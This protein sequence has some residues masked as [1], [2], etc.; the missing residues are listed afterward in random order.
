MTG[1]GSRAPALRA[2]PRPLSRGPVL[3]WGPPFEDDDGRTG[4]FSP[5][6]VMLLSSPGPEFSPLSFRRGPR[7]SCCSPRP[8]LCLSFILSQPL[9]PQLPPRALSRIHFLS[10]LLLQCD[11]ARFLSVLMSFSSPLCPGVPAGALCALRLHEGAL[12]ALSSLPGPPGAPRAATRWPSACGHRGEAPSPGRSVPCS[13][14]GVLRLAHAPPLA[15]H[16]ACTW[17]APVPHQSLAC[18]ALQCPALPLVKAL[19][20]QGG[21]QPCEACSDLLRGL[22]GFG[23][24]PIS[25]RGPGADLLFIVLFSLVLKKYHQL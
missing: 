8:A 11:S 12:L 1:E 19:L 22:P 5:T 17:L 15:S 14:S 16:L 6:F 3:P 20:S 13:R 25:R 10:L 23:V 7:M 2:A 24:C 18:S 9:C 21:T 4:A